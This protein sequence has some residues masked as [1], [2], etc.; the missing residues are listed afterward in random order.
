M[1][2]SEYA[3]PWNVGSL[4]KT[5]GKAG[6]Q[7]ALAAVPR[8]LRE[9][10]VWDWLEGAQQ[11]GVPRDREMQMH[12]SLGMEFM[13]KGWGG[14]RWGNPED[15]M[16]SAGWV[17]RPAKHSHSLTILIHGK[18][19]NTPFT[20]PSLLTQPYSGVEH[21][22]KLAEKKSTWKNHPLLQT[23]S[24]DKTR[25]CQLLTAS[26]KILIVLHSI[27]SQEQWMVCIKWWL[28]FI[29]LRSSEVKHKTIN[30]YANTENVNQCFCHHMQLSIQAHKMF[31]I[32]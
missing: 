31:V 5:Q 32:I 24:G 2:V 7:A 23:C 16:G 20:A 12:L 29:P 27:C 30:I 28:E 14:T 19:P 13:L 1:S 22:L 18:N 4:G 11:P 25:S 10:A 8:L 17:S 15:F 26:Q 9:A 3:M 6:G 21:T